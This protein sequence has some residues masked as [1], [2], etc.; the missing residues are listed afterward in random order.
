LAPTIVGQLMDTV[1][2]LHAAGT[3]VIVVE[4]SLNVALELAD[5]AAFLEKGRFRFAGPT[6]EL[7]S[8]PDVLRSVFLADASV[9]GGT[10]RTHD[11]VTGGPVLECHGITKHFGGITALRDVDLVVE[12]GR[13]VGLLGA[14]G[15]GKSTLLDCVSGFL[16]LD[17]GTVA[18][19]GEDVGGLAP[20]ERAH[21]G[22]GRSMQE[23]RLFPALTVTEVISL[24]FEPHLQCRS[25][26]AAA[27]RQP[28]V[29]EAE[30]RLAARVD[31]L[32]ELL[33]LERWRDIPVGELSTGT[34][35]I[36]Q[37]ACILAADPKVVMLDEPAGG[38]AQREVEAL[39]A[40]L[41]RVQ[42]RT[43]C[44]LV[45]V[46]HDVPLLRDLCDELVAFE[47]GEVIATG[48]PEEVL[49]HPRVIAS[50]LGDQLA[51]IERSGPR[52]A[53]VPT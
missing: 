27:L 2:A 20:H 14:N 36:V 22:L 44:A 53:P 29:D 48:T 49:A 16:P 9:G 10:A 15:A 40:L 46:E 39:L 47:A 37:L 52:T 24:A 6:A 13:I 26:A 25:I 18:I 30:W 38:L 11:S 12:P 43:G 4:Q 17:R 41:R 35:R 7:A 51:A 19:C 50:Y 33:E 45:V 8:R 32:V 3:T 23:A 34:R 21:A 31:E 42:E 28:V 1:R 5:R